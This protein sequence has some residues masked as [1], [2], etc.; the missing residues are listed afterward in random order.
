MPESQA[1]REALRTFLMPNAVA[2]IGASRDPGTIGAEILRDL[3]S[4]GFAGPVYPVNP[5]ATAINSIRAYPSISEVP[6]AVD[7]AVIVVPAPIV[8]RVA[9]ECAAKGVRALVVISAG[10]A[11]TGAEGAARQR[12]LVEVCRASRMRLIGPNCMGI[13]N[14][15]PEVRLNGSFAPEFPLHGRVGFLSQS[16]ALG[17]AVVLLLGLLGAAERSRHR[18]NL[19]QVPLRISVNGSRGKSTVTRLLAGALAGGGYRPLA[20]TTGTEPRLVHGWSGEEHPVHRRP[21]GPNIGEHRM[22]MREAVRLGVDSVVVEC[23]AVNPEYQATFHDDLLGADV[24][25]ITNVLDDHLDVMGPTAVDVADVFADAI[26][27]QGRVVIAPGPH[28]E[29]FCVA[30]ERR[31][32]KVLLADPAGVDASVL[33]SFD[34]LVFAEHVALALA[35]TDHLGIARRRALEGMREAPADPFATRMLPVGDRDAPAV[36][37]NAFPANDPVS[38]LA[39]WDHVLASG[40][41]DE[42]LVVVMNCRDDRMERSRQFADE[43]LPALPIDTLV[44]V[45]D[46]TQP[47]VR[48]VERGAIP[49]REFRD[50]SGQAPHEAVAALDDELRDRVVLAV[51]NLHGAGTGVVRAF[52]ERVVQGGAL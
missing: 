32:A 37:V 45:G 1:A 38:T 33:R 36:F 28:T 9:R 2:V 24:L 50:A 20:K 46:A 12:E 8:V 39:I 7:L 18:R 4:T 43:V 22:V 29:R 19:A 5:R 41:P 13:M 26:P 40:H 42:K 35:L 25:V 48:A 44:V 52:E 30:A 49:H 6:G 34:H 3:V 14:T 27:V 31:G 47:V 10:F 11:E 21:E 16:G 23:M 51:G 17:L 15:D